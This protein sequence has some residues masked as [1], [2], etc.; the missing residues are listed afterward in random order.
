MSEPSPPR[1]VGATQ[2]KS[3]NPTF[4]GYGFTNL[5]AQAKTGE[6]EKRNP[7]S[8]PDDEGRAREASGGI[9]PDERRERS[10][11]NGFT[12][13]ARRRARSK[14][15]FRHTGS[16]M[17]FPPDAT[18]ADVV[19]GRPSNETRSP[20]MTDEFDKNYRELFGRPPPK[21]IDR[22]GRFRSNRQHRISASI[23]P[24]QRRQR[25]PP[26]RR[27]SPP[28]GRRAPTPQGRRPRA[29]THGRRAPTPRRSIRRISRQRPPTRRRTPSPR[30][31][32]RRRP[33]PRRRSRT[34]PSDETPPP[35]PRNKSDSSLAREL[36]ADLMG[37]TPIRRI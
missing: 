35:S 23:S 1:L 18:M 21:R 30:R 8:D 17:R 34:P 7:S 20:R 36:S 27:P 4:G 10:A 25:T 32:T 26:G 11:Q 33:R 6:I 22:I 5:V 9:R 19:T 16:P 14:F 37:K 2:G 31:P 15:G 13:G 29:P 24:Q 28:H 3:D 12:D